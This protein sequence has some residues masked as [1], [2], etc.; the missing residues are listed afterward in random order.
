MKKLFTL[1][2]EDI[3]PR[4]DLNYNR[5]FL[6]YKDI[7]TFF[8]KFGKSFKDVDCVSCASKKHYVISQKDNF[9]FRKCN[10][11]QTV[12]ISPRPGPKELEWWYTHSAHIKHS[13]KILEKTADMRMVIYNERIDKLFG[14]ISSPVKT[15]LE[16]GCGTGK[17]LRL[18]KESKPQ[19][20]FTGIDISHEA[21]KLAKENGVNCLEFSAEEFAEK[22]KEQYDLILAFELLEHVFD[23][24]SLIKVLMKLLGKDG[25]LYMTMPNYLSYDFLQI[26]DVYRN[27][28]GPS[29]LNY[30][31]PFSIKKLLERGGYKSIEIFCDGVLDTDIVG[32]YHS[33]KK[34]I[35]EGFWKYIYENREKYSNFL[36]DYQKLLQ[37][38]KLSGNMT[39]VACMP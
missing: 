34:R 4:V 23:P 12:F 32:N 15:V 31:N 13:Q 26:G 27:F 17:F 7:E 1:K 22:S 25:N 8:K 38:Y 30:Y 37:K 29:H 5:E 21:V 20:K 3:R 11:C 16:V 36:I 2:E 35:L 10:E 33:D 18:L 24:I 28:F 6:Y 19:L 14:R 39:V 9:I